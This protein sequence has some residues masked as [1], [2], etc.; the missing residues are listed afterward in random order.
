MAGVFFGIAGYLNLPA[1]PPAPGNVVG[2]NDFLQNGW[3][4]AG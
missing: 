2:G 1:L 4:G 3:S